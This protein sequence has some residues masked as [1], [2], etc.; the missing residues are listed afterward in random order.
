MSAD[1]SVCPTES[2]L[3]ERL[4]VLAGAPGHA[5]E[6]WAPSWATV[7]AAHAQGRP[8]EVLAPAD[9]VVRQMPD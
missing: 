7:A 5:A 2:E 1:Q 9:P 4:G 3:W 6:P 8:A